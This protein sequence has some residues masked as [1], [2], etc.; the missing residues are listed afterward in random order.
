MELRLR[1]ENEKWFGKERGYLRR[2]RSPA[3][4]REAKGFAIC[5]RDC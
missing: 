3:G 5:E 2:V 4:E 1:E